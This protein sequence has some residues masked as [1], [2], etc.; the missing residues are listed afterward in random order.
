MECRY[1]FLP[2][3]NMCCAKHPIAHRVSILWNVLSSKIHQILCN[4]RSLSKI[5]RI[6]SKYMF[7]HFPD[8]K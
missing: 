2:R 8:S 4:V 3:L 1:I 7:N 5:V 6:Q